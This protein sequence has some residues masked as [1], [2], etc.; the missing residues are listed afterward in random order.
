MPFMA[1]AL[2]VLGQN[3][4][5]NLLCNTDFEDNQVATVSQVAIIDQ[6]KVPCWKTT[7]SDKMIEI[8]ASGFYG[9][10]SYSG[11]Q[12]AELNANE[13]STLYQ[14]FTASLGSTIS[15]SFAHRGRYGTDVLSVEIGPV[16]GP[17]TS[18]G[19]FSAGNTA[20]NYNTVTYKFPSSGTTSYTLRFKSV[21]ATGGNP[22]IGNFL[23]AI[24]L[25]L[26]PPKISTNITKP[27]CPNASDGAIKLV[28]TGGSG[29]FTF[30]WLAPLS[31]TIDSVKSIDSGIYKVT[32]EDIYGCKITKTITVLPKFKSYNNTQTIT[33]CDTFYWSANKTTYKNSGNYTANYKTSQGCD[34]VF[35]LK[36][37]INKSSKTNWNTV[38]CVQ[39]KWP[40]DG[41][42]YTQ[43]GLYTVKFKTTKGCDS[44]HNLNLT[45]R[46]TSAIT[47]TVNVCGK[48]TWPRNN[49]QYNQSGLYAFTLINSSGCDSTLRLKLTLHKPDSISWTKQSCTPYI[50]PANGK[51]Y[52][53]S[54]TYS[55][56]FKNQ[57]G[58][59]S[60]L[61]LNLKVDSNYLLHDTANSCGNYLWPKNNT[62]YNQSGIY[63]ILL[64]SA[65]GCDSIQ[66]LHLNIYPQTHTVLKI[67]ANYQYF[68]GTT[69]LTYTRDGLYQAKYKNR[70][71]CDSLL[72]L[73]LTIFTDD[74]VFIPN[75]FTPE[76][77]GINDY[78]KPAGNNITWYQI[79]IFN[80][81][82]EMLFSGNQDQ[83]FDGT[84]MG[85]P[86]PDGVYAY[87]IAIM[88]KRGDRKYFKGAVTVVR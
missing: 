6:S 29:P 48:Y 24:S 40:V 86:L 71:G 16:G 23:D 66:N 1:L 25:N 20:W 56:V 74:S 42:T 76:S 57:F 41:K 8:W 61:I 72:D 63:S 45:I 54:G 67:R 84:Y 5:C 83:P 28:L 88:N 26:S 49:S 30:K 18:L 53:K 33:A 69:G 59:D 62:L 82:G 73:D 78:F 35:N 64:K 32:V 27:T 81:W 55:L 75:T 50:W 15:L 79:K 19:S 70:F 17:Y 2:P 44:V 68:W 11:K 22:G 43:S 37:T 58:C 10:P 60:T 51:T 36:L 85:K 46:D 52:A 9:V 87:N 3:D 21:S 13:V 47:D 34:S 80:R 65:I 31:A 12:F 39:Y 77:N 4:T 38:K 14:N 7:A